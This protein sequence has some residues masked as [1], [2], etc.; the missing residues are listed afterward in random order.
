MVRR[1]KDSLVD[2]DG[3]PRFPRRVTEALE[4]TYTDAERHGHSL[5]DRYLTLRRRAARRRADDGS[6]RG[7]D[8]VALLLK[9]RM[10]SSPAAFARTLGVHRAA[11]TGEV[12][13][14]ADDLGDWDEPD[15]EWDAPLADDETGD[16]A[17]TDLLARV[18]AGERGLDPAEAHALA[19]LAGWSYT[20]AEPADS[21][22]RCL[23]D[24]LRAVVDGHGERIIV[25][26][27]WRDTQ[28]WLAE[29]LAAH[30]LGGERLGLLH[31]GLDP[32]RREHLKAAFQAD[33]ARHPVRILLAT[34]SA[35]EGIDLQRH[36]RR[37]VHY[38]IP[39][40]PNRLEQRIGRVDRH[41]QRR[42]VLVRHFVGAGW[43]AA[44]PGSCEGDLEFL[45]RVARKVAIEREDL[46]SVNPVLAQAVEHRMLGRPTF[47]DPLEVRASPGARSLKAERDLAD[48]V[49]RL[50]EQLDDS[51]ARLRTGPANVRRVVDVA[52][53]LAAQPALADAAEPGEVRPPALTRGW[54]RTVTDLADP[55]DGRLRPLAF[56]PA[57]TADRDDVVLAHLKHPLVRQST[58]LL[59]SAVWGGGTH[60]H[61]L[62]AVRA[63]LPSGTD[64]DGLLVTVFARL[65]VVGAD[66]ARLHEEVLLAGRSLPTTGRS[67][68]LDL[69]APRNAAVREAVESALDP[70]ACRSAPDEARH[71]LVA[72]WPALRDPLAR[73][74]E[75][76][77]EQVIAR[78]GRRLDDRADAERSRVTAVFDQLA[79]LLRGA[80]ATSPSPQLE[81]DLLADE[82]AQYER[83]RAA[84]QA[85][86]DG[87]PEDR[88][89]ELAQV[90]ARYSGRRS[91]VFPF[92]VALVVPDA[93]PAA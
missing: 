53:A 20:H 25:F 69:E 87:V 58:T 38:D 68:R 93:W 28:V 13:A 43:R 1:L 54:E 18:A 88:A 4:V 19:E 75:V 74:V 7:N 10:F 5:L 29:I 46:G 67:T 48:Q 41:G 47:A 44:A 84:W 34:D 30:G 8:L 21:K 26:T 76:R 32:G 15:P 64:V 49:R 81:L 85:R 22:A 12:R 42:E 57:V 40:N 23:I 60:L 91:L 24:E 51:R 59:R 11:V 56:D 45:S 50:R 65:V 3:A 92:A 83:D 39:F 36:C 35:S 73:D 27:E 79:D 80:L 82:Q 31:G 33:P 78:L 90:D 17:A 77:A 61:R 14:P 6:T 63:A 9:K 71:R 66:G 37:V 16:E 70:G 52:L 62:A 86:L 89:R 72:A 55:L 2:A